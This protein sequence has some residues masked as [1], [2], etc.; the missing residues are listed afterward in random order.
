L[1]CVKSRPRHEI[2]GELEE[3]QTIIFIHNPLMNVQFIFMNGK[4][5]GNY[6]VENLFFQGWSF[7]EKMCFMEFWEQSHI[8]TL[9]EPER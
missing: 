3:T 2:K 4:F 8:D 6:S 9:T 5:R 7:H 1:F